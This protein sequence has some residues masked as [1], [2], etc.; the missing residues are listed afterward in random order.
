MEPPNSYQNMRARRFS[1]WM[2]LGLIPVL[3]L[4]FLSMPLKSIA[5]CNT[6]ETCKVLVINSY[7]DGSYWA[8]RLMSGINEVFD[9]AGHVEYF[10]NYL[11]AKRFADDRYFQMMAEIYA[12]KFRDIDFD[13]I[14]T[15]D[16]HALDFMVEYGDSIFPDVPVVF[17]GINDYA[18]SRTAALGEFTGI[19]EHYDAVGTIELIGK[20]QPEKT[21]IAFISDNTKTGRLLSQRFLRD[22]SKLNPEIEVRVLSNLNYGELCSEIQ[23][24]P[25]NTALLWASY[26]LQPDR[27]ILSAEESM[28]MISLCRDL[29]VYCVWDV[30]G[31]G[32]IGGKITSPKQQGKVAAELVLQIFH[33]KKASEIPV[34]GGELV[35]KFDYS[36]LISNNIELSD[37]P[38]NS[39]I[40]NKPYSVYE[41]YR[42]LIWF[43]VGLIVFLSLVIVALSYHIRLRRK[44]ERTLKKR[45]EQLQESRIQLSEV[46]KH[47]EIARDKA[48]ESDRLKSAFLANLSHEIRTPMNGIMGFADLL[49]EKEMDKEKQKEYL[50]IIRNSSKRL[51]SLINDLI[52]IS[53][54]DAGQITLNPVDIRLGDLM[55]ELFLFFQA[56]ADSKKIG[57]YLDVDEALMDK[58]I[59][60]DATRL[61]QIM[62]NLINN[63]L[64][65]TRKG[66]VRIGCRLSGDDLLLWVS[67]TGPGIPEEYHQKIFERFRQ[68]DESHLKEEEG[69]GLGL[70]ISKALV[71]LMD[72]D[73]WLESGKE[74]GAVFY[75]CLPFD[76]SNVQVIDTHD[77]PSDV[78]LPPNLQV[79][80]AE[81]DNASF[82]LLEAIL[83]SFG[84]HVIRAIDG[85]Q[86]VDL[87]KIYKT[88]PLVLLDLKMPRK[89]GFDTLKEIKEIK[90]DVLAIA[91]TAYVSE[92][93]RQR[94][95]REGFNAFITK[96]IQHGQLQEMLVKLLVK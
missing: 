10:V 77:V 43:V 13:A 53:K 12:Y 18:P 61:E 16:D 26:L 96:P 44:S 57:F 25:Q 35:Y 68:V 74:E 70:S 46:N 48:E 40:I 86:A 90:P 24:L 92:S 52:D 49:T 71:E 34:R 62:S 79:M 29:P 75:V 9:S 28:E 17:C 20:L 89:N 8:D 93:D 78:K 41:K 59:K 84:L 69:S 22:K 87:F 27:T 56:E 80:V 58:T 45:N 66:E 2:L 38:D 81:D 6:K 85:E 72:G 33:G 88:I 21:T 37:L 60:V 31:L 94:C 95:F 42:T 64:K 55:E 14:L 32:A 36:E 3:H 76:A 47:L 4:S 11:D 63:A 51:L 7:H 82:E 15:S 73:I 65:F 54:I 67:D 1:F 23:L 50:N 83:A 30:V 19:W 91:Q 5:Q 39:I